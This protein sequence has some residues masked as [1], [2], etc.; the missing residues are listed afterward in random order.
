MAVFAL[1]L[2]GCGLQPGAKLDASDM[3]FAALY[4]E[5]LQRSGTLRPDSSSPGVAL[6]GAELDSLFARNGLDRKTF[7][8][9]LRSYSKNPQL[10]GDVLAQVRKNLRRQP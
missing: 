5:Y 10:W 2:S 7:D 8:A 4:G 3:K 6:S 9:K 1:L